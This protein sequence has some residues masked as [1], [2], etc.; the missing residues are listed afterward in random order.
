M[1]ILS[2][3]YRFYDAI[4]GRFASRFGKFSG[5]GVFAKKAIKPRWL[6]RRDIQK[7]NVP[8]TDAATRHGGECDNEKNYFTADALRVLPR[9]L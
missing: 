1:Y 9:F 7:R 5:K 8:E 2:S 3:L 6:T 4:S